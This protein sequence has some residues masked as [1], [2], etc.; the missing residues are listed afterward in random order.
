VR[1]AV[2]RLAVVRL[3]SVVRRAVVRRAV[4]RRASVLWLIWR[5]V[6][7]RHGSIILSDRHG[8]QRRRVW[9]GRRL[10]NVSAM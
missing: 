2:V 9:S 6:M 3:A 5:R 7:I 10:T 8:S 1:R 4:V